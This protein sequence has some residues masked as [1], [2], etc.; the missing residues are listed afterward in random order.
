MSLQVKRIIGILI[1]AVSIISLIF[2][3]YLLVKVWGLRQQWNDNLNATFELLSATIDTTDQGLIIVEQALTNA[4]T[5]MTSLESA[6]ISLG[7]T[8]NDTSL[9]LDSFV[10]L[11][12]EE[13]PAVITDTQNAI[14]SAEA[15][16]SVIDSVLTALSSIPLIGINYQPAVPLS[17]SL[18]QIASSLEPLP[19]SL[20]DISTSLD[21]TSS[22]LLALQTQITDVAQNITGINQNLTQAQGVIDQ[23]QQEV[24]QF[25]TWIDKGQEAIP[26]WI[27]TGVWIFTFILLWLAISQIN[28]FIQGLEMVQKK[29]E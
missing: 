28:L 17:T 4:S 19:N 13:I 10:T 8:V 16:F 21:S 3:L 9:V 22:N 11:F 26:G 18:E 25:Q 6:T 12:G 20:K 24:D 2:S 29:H 23:Y 5:S 7:T 1:V 27:N 14:G 15:S